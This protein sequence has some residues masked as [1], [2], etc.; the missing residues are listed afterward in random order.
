MKKLTILLLIANLLFVSCS[1]KKVTGILELKTKSF[2]ISI[3][4]KGYFC[5]FLDTKTGTNYLPKDTIAPLMS[6]IRNSEI[7]YPQTVELRKNILILKYSKGVEAAIKF[8]LKES[9]ISFELLSLSNND[10]NSKLI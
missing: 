5:K 6:V 2:Q 8:E 10:S 7:V 3:D 1:N 9:H 4:E